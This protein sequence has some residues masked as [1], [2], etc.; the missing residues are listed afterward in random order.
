M[1]NKKYFCGLGLRNFSLHTV[2]SGKI[3]KWCRKAKNF[4][5][6][7][8]FF[9]EELGISRQLIVFV[10]HAFLLLCFIFDDV[11]IME[12]GVFCVLRGGSIEEK[13]DLPN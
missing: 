4:L 8:G 13:F 10:I 9:L 5:S 3:I 12:S 11:T 7:L 2:K 6:C 1:E